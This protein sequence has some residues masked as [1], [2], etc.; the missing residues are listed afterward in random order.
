MVKNDASYS[1]RFTLNQKKLGTIQTNAKSV[2][3]YKDE[4]TVFS[5]FWV[6]LRNRDLLCCG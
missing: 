3:I 2:E 4:K 6:C 1:N 5:F